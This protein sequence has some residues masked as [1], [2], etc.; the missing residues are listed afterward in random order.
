VNPAEH[1]DVAIVGARCGGSPLATLLARRGLKVV[2]FDQVT[3]PRPALSSHVKQADSLAFLDR[4]GVIDRVRATGAP[5]TRQIDARLDDFRIVADIPHR[6]GDIGGGACIRRVVL[7]PILAEAAAE[8]GAEMR[9]ATKV[10]GL[11]KERGRVAGVRF[12]RDGS[13][14]RLHAR[15]VVGADGRSSTVAKLVGARR[16]NVVANERAYYWSYFE[17]TDLSIPPRFV[18]HRWGERF[19]IANPA[20]N[21]LYMVGCSP[22]R[23][24]REEFRRNLEPMFMDHALSCEPTASVLEGARRATKIY[25]I[26]RFDGYFR[27]ASGPGW[28]IVGDAGHFKDP[29]AGRGIGDAFLQVDRLAP[30]IVNGLAA[31]ELALDAE[32]RR[33]GRW[34]DRDFNQHYW[35]GVDFGAAGQL[36]LATPEVFRQVCAQGDTD[37]FVELLSHRSRPSQV[38]TIPRMLGAGARTMARRGADRR[39]ILREGTVRFGQEASRRWTARRPVYE[40]PDTAQEPSAAGPAAPAADRVAVG[41]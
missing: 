28:A 40:P 41:G 14:R 10:T 27:D 36:P 17:G 25:G 32:L 34:R 2:V 19:I 26:L 4:L 7:D 38:I 3:F 35:M 18:F 39:T 29:A 13:E 31:G 20:D 22:E 24:E 12:Q 11:I 37:R 6:P 8:A 16:Y 33:W 1:A 21:G 9:M 23:S 30:A 5:F 15:L